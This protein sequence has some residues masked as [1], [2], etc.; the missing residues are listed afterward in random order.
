MHPPLRNSGPLRRSG[1]TTFAS[2]LALS[3]VLPPLLSVPSHA[4]EEPAASVTPPVRV[5]RLAWTRGS[6]SFRPA[7]QDGWD[8]AV[9]NYPVNAG[10][11]LWTQPGAAAGM[12]VSDTLIALAPSTEFD[13]DRLDTTTLAAT[14]PE[15]EVYVRIGALLPGESYTLATP[16]GSV[17]IATPGRYEIAAGTT[18]SPTLVTVL[19]GAARIAGPEAVTLRSGQTAQITGDQAFTVQIGPAMRDAF[20]GQ[21]LAR[22]RPQPRPAVAPPALVAAM[23]G[24]VDLDTYG[25]WA[26][27]PDYGPVWYPQ[28]AAGWVPYREGHWAYIAPWG[29]TW[30]DDEPWGFAPFHYGRWVEVGPRWAWVPAPVA[31]VADAPPYPVYAPALVTF[32]D[33]GAGFA[34][35]VAT[36]ALFAGSVGWLP[37]APFEPYHP[38]FR[39]SPR[40]LREVNFHQV[41]NVGGLGAGPDRLDRFRNRGAATVVPASALATSRPIRPLAR[42]AP[43]GMLAQARPV[44]GR[45]PLAPTTATRGVT[46]ALAR[47]QHLT[48]PPAGLAVP[49]HRSAPGPARRVGP[50]GP[51]AHGLPPLAGPGGRVP[52][53]HSPAGQPTGE[54]TPGVGAASPGSTAPRAGAP[55]EVAPR[56]G[57]PFAG[58]AHPGPAA[59]PAL[60]APGAR[61]V[62]GE[63]GPHQAGRPGAAPPASGVHPG[64]EARP[65]VR[66]EA[67]GLRTPG[68][69]PS[70]P[71]PRISLPAARSPGPEGQGGPRV[72]Q[73]GQPGAP[74]I[75][76]SHPGVPAA[77]VRPTAPAYHPPMAHPASMSRPEYRSMPAPRV[78]PRPAYRPVPAPRPAPPPAYH[79]APAPRPAAPRA[80]PP[81]PAPAARQAAPQR[82]EHKPQ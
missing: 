77:P 42:S 4:Q 14:E 54:R 33:V 53:G 48:A 72:V 2:I 44:Q 65:A 69:R 28:V 21:M 38:Y 56:G 73:P 24:G 80:A 45:E 5:G 34:A 63:A 70:G 81:H 36:G 49:A 29:W 47:Q 76:A 50:G 37:L 15:G 18:A 3:L 55:H 25:T 32:F 31:V 40:Y 7:G 8:P 20:L 9:V 82:N 13:L 12:Q 35:G 39:A 71:A 23:P 79:P 22:E 26:S 6:V 58:P 64:P 74:R 41:R 66:P 59:L 11:S 46:P 61:P 62:L 57:A 43:A 60:R 19:Q 10:D 52:A 1:M 51:A 75:S 78:V 17:T 30:I 16:R 68:A 27:S 67:P